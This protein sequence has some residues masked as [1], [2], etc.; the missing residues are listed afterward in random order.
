MKAAVTSHTRKDDNTLG[1]TVRNLFCLNQNPEMTC[2]Y[3][4]ECLV[5]IHLQNQTNLMAR[6]E[7]AWPISFTGTLSHLRC[8]N[9]RI[10]FLCSLGQPLHQNT[11]YE[12]DS[13][14]VCITSRFQM[15]WHA[16]SKNGALCVMTGVRN[17]PATNGIHFQV[18]MT[19]KSATQSHTQGLVAV[20]LNIRPNLHHN[21]V[22]INIVYIY[23]STRARAHTHTHTRT[24]ARTHTHTHT[25]THT[26][27]SVFSN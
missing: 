5:F 21:Y 25:H 3:E 15:L 22:L 14:K 8:E 24:H 10:C 17:P 13:P 2:E 11:M 7:H 1:Y 23:I 4:F 19:S 9:L 16:L 20:P 26:G 18:A 12:N 6:H 27:G